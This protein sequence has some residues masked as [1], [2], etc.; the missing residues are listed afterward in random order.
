MVAFA[1]FW[2]MC[3]GPGVGFPELLLLV[4]LFLISAFVTGTGSLRELPNR[5]SF[6]FLAVV[7]VLEYEM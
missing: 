6:S 4:T 7:N 3:M 1:S 5:C 2:I